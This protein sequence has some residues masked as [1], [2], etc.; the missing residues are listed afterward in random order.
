M[1]FDNF[2]RI[3]CDHPKL[4]V[5][6]FGSTSVSLVVFLKVMMPVTPQHAKLNL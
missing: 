1:S 6:K 3:G 2:C 5:F 4:G